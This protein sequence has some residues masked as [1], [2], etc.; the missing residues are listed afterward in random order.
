MRENE[1]LKK[2]IRR[3]WNPKWGTRDQ[4]RYDPKQ[5]AKGIAVEREH[6]NS[7]EMAAEIAMDHLDEFPDYYDWHELMEKM[8]HREISISEIR[9]L[10]SELEHEQW[11][12]WS[13]SIAKTE[14]LSPERVERW[15]RLWIP[16]DQ[17][18][19][20]DK[21]HDRKWADRVMKIV[22]I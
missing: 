3:I 22:G 15:Q 1:E 10:L 20:S 5:L 12:T 18:S 17:L 14:N 13:Q 16:Y 6:T 2:L 8:I 21:D 7:G 9:E 11:I 4:R 19:E